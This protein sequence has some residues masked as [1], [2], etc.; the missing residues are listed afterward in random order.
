MRIRNVEKLA[1]LLV[2]IQPKGSGVRLYSESTAC[3]SIILYYPTTWKGRIP[4]PGISEGPQPEEPA[5]G[6]YFSG[7]LNGAGSFEASTSD[8]KVE[9]SLPLL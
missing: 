5:S 1:I 9:I 8:L 3:T 7:P 6:L 2:V 4:G